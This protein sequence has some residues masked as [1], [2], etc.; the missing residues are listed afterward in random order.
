VT[1]AEVVVPT[2]ATA[3]M[4][5]ATAVTEAKAL[6]EAVTASLSLVAAPT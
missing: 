4:E 5:P 6:M 1:L 3:L 2:G